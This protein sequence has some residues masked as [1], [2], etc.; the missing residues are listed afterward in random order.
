MN[1]WFLGTAAGTILVTSTLAASVAVAEPVT[2]RFVQTNDIDRMEDDDGR[3]GFARLAAVVAEARKEPNAFF[4]HSGDT[5]S[6]SLLSGIDKGVHVVEILNRMKPDVMVP[7]NHEFDFGPDVFRARI[8]E[9]TFDVVSSNIREASGAAPANTVDDKIVDVGGVKVGFYGLTTEET[10]ILATAGDV[11]F[12][13][14]IDTGRRKSAELREKGADFVV[15]VVHTPL[16]VDMILA[17][18]GAA[19]LILSGH[20]EHLLT[21]YDGKVAMTE[22]YSQADFVVV[23]TVTIDKT[24]KDGKTSVSWHPTFEV[25]DTATVTPDAEIAAVVADYQKTLDAELQV[26]IGTTTTPL[27][28][29]RSTVRSQEAAI[30]NLVADATRSAVGADIAITNGGGIRADKEYPAGSKLTRADIFAELPFGNTTVKLEL[31][32][33]QI[34]AALENGFSQVREVAGRFPQVSGLAVEVD[35]GEPPG[36]RVKSVKVGGA[37]IDPARTYTVATNDYM[38]AG[39]DGYKVFVGAKNLIDAAAAQLMASQVIDYV[40][41]A[42]TIAPAVEGRITFVE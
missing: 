40:T 20:D 1:G 9:A 11:K 29:R 28:S 13:S 41:A 31:T 2:L 39:G 7:G 24:E 14:T 5:I 16:A 12:E 19:D 21:Y 38:A 8:G 36:S 35:L 4:V 32:G 18:D 30:G 34:V 22:S 25:V 6:P 15:A 17:R 33:E 23:T 42:G 27:D 37:P 26:E 3:G 10:P